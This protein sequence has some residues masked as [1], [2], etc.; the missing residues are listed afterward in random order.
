M[1]KIGQ[2]NIENYQQRV[3]NILVNG[4]ICIL[5]YSDFQRLFYS[6]EQNYGSHSSFDILDSSFTERYGLS[7]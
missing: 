4:E 3:R 5:F 7:K 6:F 1:K 2:E